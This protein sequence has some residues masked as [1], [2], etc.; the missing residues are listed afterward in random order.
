VVW[1]NGGNGPACE[2]LRRYLATIL[3]KAEF[4]DCERR[5]R[6]KLAVW[7][8]RLQGPAAACGG[9][10]R[11]RCGGGGAQKVASASCTIIMMGKQTV[12]MNLV[13][14]RY[15]LRQSTGFFGRFVEP[16]SC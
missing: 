1:L 4:G 15:T 2:A 3:A 12:R 10:S 14:S 8:R 9:A 6:V 7:A 5:G 11:V 16:G 13:G